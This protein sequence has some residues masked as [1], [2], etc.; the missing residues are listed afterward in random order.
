[1]LLD[2]TGTGEIHLHMD[3]EDYDAARRTRR[4]YEENMRLLDD[5]GW[6]PER[7]GEEFEITMDREDL[8]GRCGA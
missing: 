4:R 5:I 7:D 2:L 6:E 8:A 3:N 1:V